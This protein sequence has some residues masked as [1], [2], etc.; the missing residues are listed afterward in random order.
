[1]KVNKTQAIYKYLPNAWTVYDEKEGKS[2]FSARIRNWNTK[3]V[4]NIYKPKV[5]REIKR[6]IFNFGFKGGDI[7]QFYRLEEDGA[8]EFYEP[9]SNE[10]NDDITVT[11]DPLVFYCPNPKCGLVHQVKKNPN[12]IHTC[13][14]CNTKLKQLQMVF[15]C[16]C[17][18]SKGVQYPHLKGDVFYWPNRGERS[19]FKFFYKDKG[20][21]REYE[22][23]D[24]C[25]CGKIL[26]PKN[27]SDKIHFIP[28]VN[29][30]VN[31]IDKKMGDFLEQGHE[32]NLLLIGRWFNMI[33]ETQFKDIIKNKESFFKDEDDS[34][35]ET[36]VQ[37]MI[38][39]LG[40]SREQA[41]M[42]I[43]HKKSG[44]ADSISTII[45]KVSNKILE[46]TDDNISL[47]AA[48]LV[49]FYSLYESSNIIKIDTAKKKSI[50]METIVEEKEIDEICKNFAASNI[51]LS[52][53][54]EIIS[55][56]YGFTRRTSSPQ[57]VTGSTQLK[58]LP[59]YQNNYYN[60]FTS[61]L[62]TEGILFEIDRVKVIDWLVENEVI[63]NPQITSEID[64][65]IWFLNNI[66]LGIIHK[67]S[68]ID[69]MHDDA[70]KVT[71]YV[72]GLLHT[73]SHLLLKASGLISGLDKDSLSELILPSIPAIF[74]YSTSIQGLTL[75]SLS[76]FIETNIKNFMELTMQEY[77]TCTFDP[78][79]S[80]NHNHSCFACTYVS[81]VTC[82]HFN[83]DLSR[84]YL[85]GGKIKTN[86]GDI[87][88]KKGFWKR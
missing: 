4:D 83:K 6:E 63:E 27:A 48:Q 65:K 52:S 23:R 9:A 45:N 26:Y 61:I 60:I 80:E 68:E 2:Y 40:V 58:L 38:E 75:G 47:I 76:G 31:L 74:I 64:A 71:K 18:K 34:V 46:S 77:E 24:K 7:T 39:L 57:N 8:F 79:C 20:N 11:I 81:D 86:N 54:V 69:F 59:F 49:E 84:A 10:G 43:K 13:K 3:K 35:I 29:N 87:F 33:E 85:Y 14:K 70:S 73:I 30:S 28:F 42:Y 55:T 21:Y 56:A 19:Q 17:G 16:E 36:E 72:Y 67:F 53:N 32:A 88:I 15:S 62:D 78:I 41:I 44:G 12:N 51:Q 1:M 22:I 82:E 66:N 50:E 37:S 5:L 25:D